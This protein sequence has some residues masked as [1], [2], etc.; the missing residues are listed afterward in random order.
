MYALRIN[1]FISCQPLRRFVSEKCQRQNRVWS[2]QTFSSFWCLFSSSWWSGDLFFFASSWSLLAF[3]LCSHFLFSKALWSSLFPSCNTLLTETQEDFMIH[4]D[5]ETGVWAFTTACAIW[6]NLLW[7]IRSSLCNSWWLL[8]AVKG[9]RGFWGLMRLLLSSLLCS[10][11]AWSSAYLSCCS[12]RC[13]CMAEAENKKQYAVYILLP[14]SF[15]E[16]FFLWYSNHHTYKCNSHSPL[17]QGTLYVW[18]LV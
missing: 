8:E 14:R 6:P 15:L 16:P 2:A 3:I 1:H 4:A 7:V 5:N 10:G 12:V 11:G 13:V 18:N 17:Q 9:L